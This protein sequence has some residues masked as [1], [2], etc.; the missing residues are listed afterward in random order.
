M[1]EM[2][3]KNYLIIGGT[4]LFFII[5]IVVIL[6][7]G[8]DKNNWTT[9]IFNSNNYEMIMK[10][11]SGKEKKLNNTTLNILSEKWNSLSNNGPWTGD[12]TACY[13]T[14]TIS[15][16]T[17]GIIRKKE[18]V[19]IDSSSVAFLSGGSSIYY[20]NANEVINYLNEQFIS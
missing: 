2:T 14:L 19:L 12:T 11:C 6:V 18:I 17:D 8:K 20:T 10:D 3:K 5:A 15:Y 4:A 13:T 9:E 1:M 16:D 7:L